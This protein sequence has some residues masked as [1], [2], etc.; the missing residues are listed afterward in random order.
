[1]LNINLWTHDGKHIVTAPFNAREKVGEDLVGRSSITYG[2]QD[3]D[4]WCQLAIHRADLHKAL[5][6]VATSPDGS[7]SPVKILLNHKVA[8]IVSPR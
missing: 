1:V 2:G 8:S 4:Y 6:N 7:G 3:V 5:L